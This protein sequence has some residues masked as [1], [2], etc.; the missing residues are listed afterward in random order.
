MMASGEIR[1][2][3]TTMRRMPVLAQSGGCYSLCLSD[4]P[5]PVGQAG[6]VQF[7][8]GIMGGAAGWATTTSIGIAFDGSGNAALYSETGLGASTGADG[9]IFV[10]AHVSNAPSVSD[11]Q[12]PFAN[13]SVGGGDLAHAT[14]DVSVGTDLGG[15]LVVTTGFTVG[16]GAGAAQTTTITQTNVGQPFN[17]LRALWNTFITQVCGWAICGF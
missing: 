12:G 6:T 11:L 3:A 17:P 15:R 1:L 13:A 5:G 2:F 7:G 14:A 4:A 9:A 10:G 16:A 8:I